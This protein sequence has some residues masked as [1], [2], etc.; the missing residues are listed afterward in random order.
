MSYFAMAC[1]IELSATSFNI[2][3]NMCK[4]LSVV[5]NVL[6]WS[7]HATPFGVALLGLAL[8][9]GASYEQAPMRQS[10]DADVEQNMVDARMLKVR[11]M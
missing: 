8:M 3:G 6:A 5:I 7:N 9:G 11:D 1:R 10:K 4:I 2:L